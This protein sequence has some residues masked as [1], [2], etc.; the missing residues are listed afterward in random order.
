VQNITDQIFAA[1]K[2]M[3]AIMGGAR[4][5]KV[6]DIMERCTAK[7]FKP[8][9]VEACIEDYEELNV[10]QVSQKRDRITFL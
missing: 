9:A 10:W 2:D 7:G 5:V 1:I 6:S 3:V 8:D 4:T